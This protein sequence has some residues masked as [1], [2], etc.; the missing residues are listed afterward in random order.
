MKP[1]MRIGEIEAHRYWIL[2]NYEGKKLFSPNKSKGWNPGEPHEGERPSRDSHY[3]RGVYAFKDRAVMYEWLARHDVLEA[4]RDNWWRCGN[5]GDGFFKPVALVTG[6]IRM[7]GRVEE[8]PRGYTAQYA[9]VIGLD[10]INYGPAFEQWLDRS[11][12][13]VLARQR[14]EV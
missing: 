7:W 14:Y 9:R 5:E 8:G 13:L 11:P 6:T 1:E 2:T 3:F 10:Q 4:L 12:D